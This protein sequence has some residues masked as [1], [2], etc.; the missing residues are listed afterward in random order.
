MYMKMLNPKINDFFQ[1]PSKNKSKYDAMAVGKNTIGNWMAEISVIAGLSRRYTN[2]QLQKT[3]ATGMS[4]GGVA[5]P[6][7]AHH[8][9]H[10]DIQTLQHYLDKP[11]IE[12]KK[13]NAAALHKYTVS[14]ENAQEAEAQPEPQNNTLA[15]EAT[16]VVNT[17]NAVD[18]QKEN[19]QP[20]NAII[21]FEANIDDEHHQPSK[22]V[23]VQNSQVVTNQ[24]KQAPMLFGGATFH[25]C[26]INL[27]IPQ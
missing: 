6:D 16:P 1:C 21:P 19:V 2:H 24:L 25:N 13:Q 26:T 3:T 18:Q 17:D 12:R 15:I 20:E 23:A 22:P 4:L 5:I 10:K 8:L 14:A 9:K 7:I 27:N 11:T